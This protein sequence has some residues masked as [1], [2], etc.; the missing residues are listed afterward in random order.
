M[1][2]QINKEQLLHTSILRTL[3]ESTDDLDLAQT[4][5]Q[6]LPDHLLKAPRATLAAIDQTA[7]DLHSVQLA[8]DEDLLALKPL[9]TFCIDELTRA[10]NGKWSADFDVEKDLLSLPGVDC[11]CPATSTD[12][13]GIQTVPHATQSLLQ[14]AMQN[15]SEDEAGGAF[16]DGSLV[17][18]SSAPAGVN[19]LTPATFAALCRELDLGRR[20]QEHFQQVFGLR[21]S[22]GKVI[23]TSTMTRDVAK[24]KRL[25]LQL[26][27]HL[28]ALKNHLTPMGVQTLQTL[29]DADGQVSPKT[30]VYN[31][32]PLIMQGIEIL[33]SCIW[34]V[35]VFS[36]RSVEAYP[37]E[38]CLVYM[39]AEPERPLYEYSSFN[40]F[41]QYLTRQLKEK[42]YKEYFANSVDE[43][44]KADF[45]KTFAD[46]AELG[47]I[48]QLPIT[49]PLFEFM[50]QSHVGK[51]QLDARKLAVP[52]EDIDEEVRQKRLLDFLQL[53]VTVAS[54]AGLVVPVLGQ[55]MMGVAV[56]QLLSE[57]YEG[58]E[59][60]RRGDQ[61]Q[62]LSHLLSVV[63][64]IA[65]MAVFA[66][67][68]K[69]LG[70]LGRKLVK[71][72]PEFFAQFTAIH[73]QAGKP[74]LWKPDLI[75]Y[76]HK[77]PWGLTMAEDSEEFYQIGT[78][79]LGRVDHRIFAG[80]YEPEAEVWRLEHP[81]R[82]QAY[83]PPL[84]RHVEGGWRLATDDAEQW[85]NAAYTLKRID[86]GLSEFS[87]SDLDMI[88][89]LSGTSHDEVLRIFND[90]LALPDRLR[91]S[92]ERVRIERQLRQ[93]I[94][95]LE[96]GEVHS[97]QPLEAQLHGLP[98]LPGWPTDRY[99]EITD[100][101]GEIK[102]TYPFTQVHDDTA[103]VLLTEDQLARGE[104]LQAVI[105][106]LYR[107]EVEAL[108]GKKVA[109][110]AEEQWLAKTLG[111]AL[112]ADRRAVFEHL[113]K[114]YDQSDT[115]P[116]SQWRSGFSSLPGRYAQTLI[117]QASSVERVHL[118][119]TARL[120]LRLAQRVRAAN[121]E[122]RLDRALT[123]FHLPE[124]ANADTDRLA[125]Q[126]LPHLSGWDP[127]LRLVMR[128]KSLT[129]AIIESIGPESAPPLKTCTLVK[130]AAGYE[131]FGGDGKSL[132]KVADHP[133]ALYSGVLK[134]L[135]PRQRFA[136][137]FADPVE[138]DAER[139]RN[140]LCDTAVDEREAS[141]RILSRGKAASVVVESACMQAD[142]SPSTNHPRA[143]VRKVRRLYP[144]LT[145]A[146]ASA[147]IDELGDDPLSRATRVQALRQDLQNLRATLRT[148]SKDE[149]ALKAAGGDWRELRHSR[150]AVAEMIEDGFRRLFWAKDENG[151]SVC[152]LNLDGMRVASLPT[153]PPG[154]NFDHIQQLSM[155]NMAQ[156]DDVAYFLKAFKQIESLELDD[157]AMTRLP[158]VLSHMP[159]L[160]RLSL[161]NNQIGLTE[162][163]L[164]KLSQLRT[165]QHLNL[166]ANSLGATPDVSKMF[167]LR[168]LL[169]RETGLREMPK[170]LERLPSLDWVDLR[171]NQIKDLPGWLFKTSRRFS[172]SLNLRANPLSVTSQTYLATYRNNVGVGMGYLENDIARLD[173]QQARSLWFND[174]VGHDWAKRDRIWTAFKEDSRAEGLFHLLSELGSTADSTRVKSAM[175]RRVWAVLEAAESD[176]QLCD[177]VLNLAANPINCT[178]S[179]AMNFSYLEVAV[180]VDRITN[181]AGGRITS[182]KPLLE[183]GRGLFRLDQLDRVAQEHAARTST[184]DPLEVSLA[185]RVGLADDLNLPGQPRHMRFAALGGV[186][187]A[188]LE[189]AK[190]NV[191]AAE[192][193]SEW[194]TFMQR[195]SFWCDYL[196]RTYDRQFAVIENTFS[197]KL[198]AVF[199]QADAL[200]SAD[201]LSEM[202]AVRLAREMAENSLLTRL[203]DDAIRL[204]NL[205]ICAMPEG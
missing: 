155:K 47:H 151:Q 60:W 194:L 53:G 137:G 149:A 10:L 164:V 162:Q 92:V 86:P 161:A 124:I 29:L 66:G 27:V 187:A 73:N 193:S 58:V 146:Q 184:A 18:L 134:A 76:E 85:N 24:M 111:A 87:D 160:K 154:L 153:L 139:L 48:K 108:L 84:E 79:T 64:D 96:L 6:S 41:K 120:P 77:L 59:D 72:H 55:L 179:A 170:G 11:G 23:A 102:A 105:D 94:R 12:E 200:S 13:D 65:S 163:T 91:D 62:A 173:E 119:D 32:H 69:V 128:D 183:L 25:L 22:D 9:Q 50:A 21:S 167:D 38:W 3:L 80:T 121:S 67:G 178:D 156:G 131:A 127:E 54:V 115:D 148:W 185:Y 201:Y 19:G 90:N 135:P 141:Q 61:Q 122:V 44:A 100:A 199:Q 181:L 147:L 169:L 125:I 117:D 51:L 180:E 83:A 7:R 31:K 112:K 159:G 33:D 26:D 39:A 113:Y 63:E 140:Q 174:G 8:V 150:K 68:Q 14:A 88:R 172:Q 191:T 103:C 166:N 4:L 132:G 165:L 118:N 107:S 138:A 20:Y 192:L 126:L 57:V 177:Q 70:T 43:D 46:T 130:S 133:D 106:G 56:G 114:G 186:T 97:G 195:Q 81:R 171:S 34:G 175:Q 17:R 198:D 205:G 158:E 78:K 2:T 30:L 98:K 93:L 190:S 52:T 204:A 75:T 42:R 109:T 89:R 202:E 15:F 116:L 203:T 45:F 74:R 168:R 99:L 104:L 189:M 145:G 136:A 49:V 35:V 110:N 123:G 188:D 37:E 143:L 129:G 197:P 36:V 182:A 28:A 196:K 5:Q 152:T 40:A 142:P 82:S 71:S 157:N 176:A 16:P 144:S 95:E 101:E 1:P